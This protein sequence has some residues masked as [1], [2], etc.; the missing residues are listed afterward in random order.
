ME[1]MADSVLRFNRSRLH[2]KEAIGIGEIWRTWLTIALAAAD[3]NVSSIKD[4][5]FWDSLDKC[6]AALLVNY[7]KLGIKVQERKDSLLERFEDILTVR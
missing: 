2:L 7:Q 5:S 1:P 3:A 6:I 4:T